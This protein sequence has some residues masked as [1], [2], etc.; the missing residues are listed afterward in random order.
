MKKLVIL[1]MVLLL[2]T[3]LVVIAEER[4]ED[5]KTPLNLNI[6][7]GGNRFSGTTDTNT[8]V[9]KSL[10]RAKRMDFKNSKYGYI[11][12]PLF[13]MKVYAQV[14]GKSLDLD[15]HKGLIH[16]NNYRGLELDN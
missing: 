5:E 11:E 13:R 1:S 9:L 14:Y 15:R 3:S 10:K 7:L 8:A 12:S 4:N 16:P 6:D 2:I